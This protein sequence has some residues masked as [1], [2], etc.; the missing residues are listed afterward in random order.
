MNEA[1]LGLGGNIGDRLENIRKTIAALEAGCGEI[2]S[3]S[4]IYETDAWGSDSQK[5][6]LNMALGL[7]THLAAET[8]LEKLLE[9]EAQ[10]GRL[11]TGP[12]NSDRTVDID[13]L[14]FNEE[15]LDSPN[16]QIP[17]PMLH[18]R[19]FV[20]IP[21]CDIA[22]DRMHPVLKKSM[23]ELLEICTDPLEVKHFSVI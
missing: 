15:I 22:A 12:Q 16:I 13:I 21:L 23:K 3:L 19:K 1:F 17:H 7:N 18:L 4:G 8:L 20:L 5:K 10:L 11:R 9:I 14:L 2:V 6:Y